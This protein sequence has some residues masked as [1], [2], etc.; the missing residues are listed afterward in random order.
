MVDN[1]YSP[2][3]Y[4]Y[5]NSVKEDG[6]IFCLKPEDDEKR[7]VVYRTGLSFVIMNLYPYNNGHLMVVPQ[8]HLSS[9]SDLS[10]AEMTDLFETVIQAESVLK[11][12]YQTDGINIGVNLGKAAGAGV[13]QHLHIHIVPRWFG[14]SNFMTVVG[15]V[16]VIPESFNEASTLLKKHF[17]ELH[18]DDN[19]I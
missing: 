18:N 3:R 17:S 7:L 14:D 1:L 15:S 19:L 10:K 5:L 12:R 9:L 2:W 8:R 4:N 13:D 16:R 6:C 11:K